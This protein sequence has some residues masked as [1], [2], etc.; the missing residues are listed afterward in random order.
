MRKMISIVFAL[1]IVA[2]FAAAIFASGEV[3]S[4]SAPGS[5]VSVIDRAP[6]DQAEPQD[7]NVSTESYYF[8]PDFMCQI[9]VEGSVECYGSD[10]HDV[11]SEVPSGTGFTQIDGGD[12][13]ACAYNQTDRFNYCWGSITRRPRTTQPT[14]TA[15]PAA[16][17]TPTATATTL[18][19]GVTPQPTAT[20][21]PVPITRTSCHITRPSFATYPLTLT[22]AWV[23]GCTLDDGTPFIV[24]E[25]RQNGTTSVT[26]TA[27]S[28]G[29]PNLILSEIDNRVPVGDGGWLTLLAHND[30]IDQDGGNYDAQIV[31]TLEDGKHYLVVVSPYRNDT[32][33]NFT[34]TYTSTNSAGGA[35]Y[36]PGNYT[37]LDHSQ[38]RSILESVN[39]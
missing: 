6:A 23:D 15:T 36:D 22:G 38:I 33:D 4:F 31:H 5:D 12:T 21:T 30:D 34:L 13:Y 14:A 26:I 28:P 19:P 35:S 9:F 27:S 8:G 32:R 29:D 11:V 10:A 17:A 20:K 24:D 1:A 18:P 39:E 3:L 37:P 7:Y 25:F 16:T 2:L